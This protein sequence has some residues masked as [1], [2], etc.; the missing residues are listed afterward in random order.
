VAA[1]DEWA[2]GE[3]DNWRL[4]LS[5]FYED[6][7][8]VHLRPDPALNAGLRRLH[9]GGVRLAC[10]SPGPEEAAAIV[11]HHLGLGRQVERIGVGGPTAA[12][13]LADELASSRDRAL[14]A[15][16]DAAAL[17]EVATGGAAIALA[18]WAGA[19]ETAGIPVIATPA[20]LAGRALDST[21]VTP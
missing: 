14:V 12:L 7:I 15:G 17:Q 4:E 2:A 19:P 6:H 11:V 21:A 18:W 5:R 1:L 16:D 9:A 8:P 10:W 3:V 13:A 20:D